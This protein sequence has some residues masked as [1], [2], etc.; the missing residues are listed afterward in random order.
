MKFFRSFFFKYIRFFATGLA[1]LLVVESG[2]LIYV[3]RSVLQEKTDVK[4]QEIKNNVTSKPAG[5]KIELDSSAKNVKASYDGE[6]L[7]YTSGGTLEILNLIN[8][9][10]TQIPMGQNMNLG[11]YKWVYDRD[12]LNIAEISGGYSD[13]AKLYNLD[14]KELASSNVPVEIVNSANTT[15]T[16]SA[17]KIP[18]ASKK[19]TISDIDFSTSTVITYLKVSR[20]G[21][22][23]ILRKFN[24]PDQNMP[25]SIS[26]TNIGRIQCLKDQD[27]LLYEN[28]DTGKVCVAGYG[29]LNIE[30]K[31][32]FRLLGFD[33]SDNVYLASGSSGTTDRVYY[34]SIETDDGS[35]S[36][37]VN[38]Y[39]TM[40]S[41]DL[42]QMTDTGNIYISIN[43]GI[44]VND[45]ANNIFTNAVTGKEISYRGSVLSVYGKG[46]ITEDNG[47][48]LQN[49][50][51]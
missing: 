36:T 19:S 43:G 18:L 11:F 21:Y 7:A 14:A 44:Y 31:T 30:G 15:G 34:G 46:F 25:Y 6:Y 5:L 35:G 40:Q 4:V 32:Q 1:I 2:A 10:K 37:T 45:S 24:L 20:N 17:A 27:A 38:L 47:E 50:F 23:D 41:V 28:K 13:Y 39:P 8:G 51:D 49:S 33:S 29:A 3:D 16:V 12:L 9:K 48:V 26:A 22:S 42:P